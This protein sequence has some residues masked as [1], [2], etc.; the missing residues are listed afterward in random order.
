MVVMHEFI[1]VL[2]YKDNIKTE[3]AI[4]RPSFRCLQDL[5]PKKIALGISE[6]VR[7][8]KSPRTHLNKTLIVYSYADYQILGIATRSSARAG[9]L[10][11]ARREFQLDTNLTCMNAIRIKP[12]NIRKV[13]RQHGSYATPYS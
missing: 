3:G 1:F 7:G 11:F 9:A 4:H 2:Q 12:R 6:K 5:K 8:V 13:N 10:D